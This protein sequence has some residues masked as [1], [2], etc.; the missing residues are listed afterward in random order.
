METE[1]VKPDCYKCANRRM[2]PGEAHSSCTAKNARIE[3]NR[4]GIIRGWFSWPYNYD[5]VWLIT[6]DSFTPKEASSD[7]ATR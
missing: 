2:I 3:G 5:P 4:Q 7:S 1:T 6:C